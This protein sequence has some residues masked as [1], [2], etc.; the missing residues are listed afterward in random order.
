MGRFVKLDKETQAKRALSF[1]GLSPTDM[2][3]RRTA[4][5]ANLKPVNTR[6]DA[7]SISAVW[8]AVTLRAD[9]ISTLPIETYRT[10]DNMRVDTGA[11]PFINSPDFME[12]LYSSQVE[13]DTS[14]N[15]IGII[16]SFYPGMANVPA[17]IDLQPSAAC[18]IDTTDGKITNYKIYGKDY[19]PEVI[20]HEKQVTVAG[21]PVGLSPVAYAALTLGQFATVQD[22]ASQWFLSGNGPRAEL[23]NTE[24]KIDSREATIAKESW[25]ATQEMGEPFVHGSDWEYKLISAQ[26]ASNDWLQAQHFGLNEAARY[27]RVPSDIIDAAMSGDHVTYANVIQRNLQFLVMYLGPAIRRRE[28]SLS[29]LLPRPRNFKFDEDALLR[30]D[31]VTRAGMIQTMIESRQLAPSE[32]RAM[33]NRMPFTDEQITEFDRLGLNRRNS[34]P[35]TTLAPI[36]VTQDILNAVNEAV[37]GVVGET[38]PLVSVPA[39][40]PASGPAE[41]PSG[42]TA[43][44]T[45]GKL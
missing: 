12:F 28:N 20:W 44:P 24:K 15:A 43:E 10:V 16:R 1:W 40:K 21:L 9:L 37:T 22:F 17:E 6:D 39:A 8:A 31:P 7:L 45:Q 35:G 41:Q 14:G 33:D 3:A 36:P 4:A 38:S 23:A 32:A 25:K 26:S 29:K 18:Q 5:R 27:F 34:T 30:M 42:D 2:V 11:T 19:K 13:L